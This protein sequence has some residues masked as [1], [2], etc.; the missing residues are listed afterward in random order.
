MS[1]PLPTPGLFLDGRL[2]QRLSLSQLLVH[3]SMVVLICLSLSLLLVIPPWLSLSTPLPLPTPGY[4]S[5]VDLIYVS[6]SPYSWF[7]PPWLS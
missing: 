7:I 5:M 2:Y 1:L 4:S 6:T 3:S